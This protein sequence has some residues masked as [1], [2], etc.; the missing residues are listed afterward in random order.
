MQSEAFLGI[1]F[2]AHPIKSEAFLGIISG[3]IH[4][5][6]SNP[7]HYLWAH[8]RTSGSLPAD[9]PG[10]SNA[11]GSIPRHY[12]LGPF[13]GIKKQ[14][15]AL[16]L[17]PPEDIGRVSQLNFPGPFKGIRKVSS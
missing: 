11:I 9:F 12:F 6:E 10:P 3:P 4:A 13:E 14:P 2:R 5:S 15:L 1:I 8:L 7:Q 16:F 17:G